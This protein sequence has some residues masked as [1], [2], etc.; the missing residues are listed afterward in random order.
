MLCIACRRYHDYV[1]ACRNWTRCALLAV[2]IVSD[3]MLALTMAC[4]IGKLVD[5]GGVQ[6]SSVCSSDEAVCLIIYLISLWIEF[7]AE[8]PRFII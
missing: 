2:A 5:I 1:N 6:L 3:A 8:Q 4:E 7:I